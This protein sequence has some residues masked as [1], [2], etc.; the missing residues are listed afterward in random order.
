MAKIAIISSQA[1]YPYYYITNPIQGSIF[2]A[3]SNVTISWI[4]GASGTATVYLLFGS[5]ASTMR[6]TDIVFDINGEDGE[7]DWSVPSNLSQYTTYSLMISYPT[8]SGNIGVAYSSS[9]IITGISSFVSSQ[10]PVV[11]MSSTASTMI[12]TS[13]PYATPSSS[14]LSAIPSGTAVFSSSAAVNVSVISQIASATPSLS[15]D[16]SCDVINTVLNNMKME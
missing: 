16:G 14:S 11:T 15:N 13:V 4:N 2:K 1:S 8:E 7:Y 12:S 3:G 10:A 9:F 6:P 5:D